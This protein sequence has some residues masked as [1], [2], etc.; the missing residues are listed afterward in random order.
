MVIHKVVVDYKVKELHAVNGGDL[1]GN[2][3]TK[4]F[5]AL[6]GDIL[7]QDFINDFERECPQQWFELMMHFERAKKLV[8]DDGDCRMKVIIPF[9]MA[10]RCVDTLGIT[11]K[12]AFDLPEKG[13][14]FVAGSIILI[15]A[16]IQPLFKP[17]VSAIVD[18][19]KNVLDT[20][21]SYDLTYIL[22]VGGFSESTFLQKAV[23]EKF[24]NENC[25]VLVPQETQLAV[26][27]GAVLYGH[28]QDQVITRIARR[29]YGVGVAVNFIEGHHDPKKLFID[30]DGTVKCRDVF[31][32]LIE[33]GEEVHL[34]HN[35]K[36]KYDISKGMNITYIDL[37]CSQNKVN[38]TI[39]YCDD[40]GITKLALIKLLTPNPSGLKIRNITVEITLGSTELCVEAKDDTS[41]NKNTI[42][43]EVATLEK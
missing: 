5:V 25:K 10:Q 19:V 1:G 37:L 4:A 11:L 38:K 35:V 28:H 33:V 26:I 22:M 23:K 21:K 18:S 27:K 43:V 24:E 7:G 34:G 17:V 15:H 2:A 16:A 31:D 29:T 14:R 6:L 12:R 13:I 30:E 36:E 8:N 41:G 32:S 39:Q 3:V 42:A 20:T 40:E 9:E